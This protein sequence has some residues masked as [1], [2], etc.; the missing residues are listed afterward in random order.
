MPAVGRPWPS[1]YHGSVD[2]VGDDGDD[3]HGGVDDVDD[4]DDDG[5]D[6]PSSSALVS[7]GV[8]ANPCSFFHYL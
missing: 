3:F 7:A 8:K 1:D 5:Q 2:E 4:D 6:H